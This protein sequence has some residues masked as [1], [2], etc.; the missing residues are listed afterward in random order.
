[1]KTWALTFLGVFT[2]II[3]ATMPLLISCGDDDD[4]CGENDNSNP[5]TINSFP[6]L[7][8]LT[9]LDDTHLLATHDAKNAEGKLNDP[10]VS[11]LTL[12]EDLEV[13]LTQVDMD[14]GDHE[15]SD[16]M[17]SVCA[18]S[19]E[20]GDFL[21]SESGQEGEPVTRIFRLTIN[22]Q[23]NGWSGTVVDVFQLPDDTVNVEGIECLSSDAQKALVLI[24][25][26]GG[27]DLCPDGK[28]R[29]CEIDL[30]T[31]ELTVLEE[32]VISVDNVNWTDP[33]GHRDISDLYLDSTGAIWAVATEDPADAGPWRSAIYQAGTVDGGIL[34]V[35]D[36]FEIVSQV[37][38]LKVESL[39][40]PIVE[41][42]RFSAG[43]D[44]ESYG[45]IWR[46]IP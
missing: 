24:G 42:S 9:W 29:L 17:E 46:P 18:L 4:D 11:V 23:G 7:S 40:A 22:Q 32:T 33:D 34:T 35:F 28:L 45:G 26:R 2:L 30:E 14:W 37:D 19:V 41:G 6:D 36:E 39:A 21:A 10:R 27:E 16:D 31:G 3:L 43:T 8:G 15:V 38:G 1:M 5:T 13:T 12:T 25:E 20:K 44:D